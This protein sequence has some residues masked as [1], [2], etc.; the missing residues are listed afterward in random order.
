M[1]VLKRYRLLK[2]FYRVVLP[3]NLTICLYFLSRLIPRPDFSGSPLGDLVIRSLIWVYF[4]GS[5]WRLPDIYEHETNPAKFP[6][7]EAKNRNL[8]RRYFLNAIGAGILIAIFSKMV[9][10]EF[11]PI[12]MKISLVLSIC[13]GLLFTIP[14]MNQYKI[15]KAKFMEDE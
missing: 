6:Y 3:I 4:F 14:M 8:T 11:V 1:T 13:N 15:F 10:D 2:L 5:Y 9:L 7:D 12:L